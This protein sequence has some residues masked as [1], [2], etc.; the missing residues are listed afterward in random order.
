MSALSR[1]LPAATAA[2]R[3]MRRKL[4]RDGGRS[5]WRV[6]NVCGEYEGG[7]EDGR[8]LRLHTV[9]QD[10]PK[11]SA[12]AQ[13]CATDD[14]NRC[15]GEGA[16]MARVRQGC[17]LSL[18]L[19][20]ALSLVRD[21]CTPSLSRSLAPSPLRSPLPPCLSPPSP[22][23]PFLSQLVHIGYTACMYLCHPRSPPF[24][25]DETRPHASA[26]FCLTCSISLSR[27]ISDAQHTET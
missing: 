19:V 2:F 27:P 7:A 5:M 16:A 13:V 17:N 8:Q 14:A 15:K 20:L 26:C 4:R 1:E 6:S 10:S 22:L 18:P 23:L 9:V 3:T 25:R 12:E 11:K 21:V 24:L